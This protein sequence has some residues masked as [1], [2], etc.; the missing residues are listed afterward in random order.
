MPIITLPDGSEAEFPD[1]MPASEIEAVLRRQFPAQQPVA[2]EPGMLSRIG[3]AVKGFVNDAVQQAVNVRRVQEGKGVLTALDKPAPA[4]AQPS[5]IDVRGAPVSADTYGAALQ[6]ARSSAPEQPRGDFVA[7]MLA[8][9]EAQAP[10]WKGSVMA[11]AKTQADAEASGVVGRP[12]ERSNSLA[13]SYDEP[14]ADT[15]ARRAGDMAKS[16]AQIPAT[17]V[18]SSADIVRLFGADKLGVKTS[19]WAESVNRRIEGSKSTGHQVEAV[20]F[21]RL[22]KSE[23]ATPY[24]ALMFLAEHPEFAVEQAIPS[25]GSM[26]IPLGS[27]KTVGALAERF[28]WFSKL[29]EAQRAEKMADLLAGTG[30]ASNAA[31]NGA[32][33]FAETKGD[34]LGRYGSAL[35]AAGGTVAF[36]KLTHG[37]AEGAL[38]RGR[39][40]ASGAA[41][42][43]KEVGKVVGNEFL[44]EDGEGFSQEIGKQVAETGGVNPMLALRHGA[45][46]GALGTITGGGVGAL[47]VQSADSLIGRAIDDAG[48]RIDG[49]GAT[50]AFQADA[51]AQARNAFNPNPDAIDPVAQQ[52]LARQRLAEATKVESQPTTPLTAEEIV[53]QRDAVLRDPSSIPN[54]RAAEQQQAEVAKQSAKTPQAV[55][56]NP[57][58]GSE[59]VQ[60]GSLAERAR[61]AVAPARQ[62]SPQAD[63]EWQAFPP[64]MG[65]LGVPRAEMP[66]IKAEHRGPL[67]NFLAARGI[68][69]EQ[70]E[71]P[72]RDLKP[73]QAEF[74]VSKVDKAREFQGGDRSILVSADG[75]ILDGHHQW[76][77]KTPENQPVKVI[78]LSAPMSELLPAAREFPSSTLDTVS[79]QATYRSKDEAIVA[80]AE[81]RMGAV[82]PVKLDSGRWALQPA[83]GKAQPTASLKDMSAAIPVSPQED[84]AAVDDLNR[85]LGVSTESMSRS[86]KAS[87]G[88]GMVT[89]TKAVSPVW[90]ATRQAM[91]A[92]GVHGVAV[93]GLTGGDGVAWRNRNGRTVAYVSQ[94]KGFE[95]LVGIAGHEG[96]HAIADENPELYGRYA[97]QLQALLQPKA[98]QK[99]LTYERQWDP[100]STKERARE[101]VLAD[102]SGASWLRE[103]FWR[104]VAELDDNLFRQLRYRFMANMVKMLDA[105]RLSKA[106][107]KGDRFAM[108]KLVT[109]VGRAVDLTA[110]LWAS[111]AKAGRSTKTSSR[112]AA[113]DKAMEQAMASWGVKHSRGVLAEVAP[114]PDKPEAK[115]WRQL[116]APARQQVTDRV[117]KRLMAG[118]E[119]LTKL[120]LTLEPAKGAYE[121]EKNP[122]M[123]IRAEGASD[124]D[125][126]Q[127]ARVVGYVLDQK[128]MVVFDESDAG[129]GDQATFV[130]VVLPTGM[131]TYQVESL[132]DHI[133]QVA[134]AL[135]GDHTV[136]DGAIAYGNFTGFGDNPMSDDA[137]HDAIDQAVA[138]FDWSGA[139]IE[140]FRQRFRSELIQPESRD[141][142]LEGTIYGDG[143]QKAAQAGRD[144][145]WRGQWG[146]DVGVLRSVADDIIRTRDGW[147]DAQLRAAGVSRVAAG[148]AQ[149]VGE[150]HSAG[151]AVRGVES[152]FGKP[153]DGAVSVIGYHYSK[154]RQSTLIGAMYGSGLKG[155]E[156]ARLDGADSRLKQ[157]IYFYVANSKGVQ[158]ESGVGSHLHGVRLDNLYD[159]RADELG[160]VKLGGGPNAWEA[161][162]I[163]AGF[164]GYLSP[165]TMPT[166]TA[167][168]LGPHSVKV[169]YLGQHGALKYS[170]D[171]DSN[172]PGKPDDFEY[173][174]FEYE[175]AEKV[176]V[177]DHLPRD[178]QP[179]KQDVQAELDAELGQ[180]AAP[181]VDAQSFIGAPNRVRS[182]GLF[183]EDAFPEPTWEERTPE[184]FVAK[185]EGPGQPVVATVAKNKDGSWNASAYREN[186]RSPIGK[187]PGEGMSLMSVSEGLAKGY[188][189]R[190]AAAFWID[191]EGYDLVRQVDRKAAARVTKTWKELAK[192]PGAFE[193]EPEVADPLSG[194]G[195]SFASGGNVQRAQEIADS[196]L[197]GSRF[198]FD[199]EPG[200]GGIVF[201]PRFEDGTSGRPAWMTP[202]SGNQVVF[203]AQELEKG[204]GWG[205]AFYQAAVLVARDLGRTVRAD[206]SLTSI[207][208]YRRTEQSLSA[209][210]RSGGASTVLPGIAQRVYGFE[211]G[212]GKAV[213]DANLLRLLLASA[214]NAKEIAP[215]ADALRYDIPTQTFTID[216]ENA[217]ERVS[218]FLSTPDARATGMSKATLARAAITFE[219]MQGQVEIPASMP[220]PLLYSRAER[221]TPMDD[222]RADGYK[223]MS[224]REVHV[225]DSTTD[226]GS[227]LARLA[228]T[229]DEMRLASQCF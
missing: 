227:R 174:P 92:M 34:L 29:P 115:G 148:A 24:T 64:D 44:Q 81:G 154:G 192:L 122:A 133:M 15:V 111:K 54:R 158:P 134:P 31:M 1:D 216:G 153:R 179:N 83:Q 27:A 160:L 218:E 19:D 74:S 136:R 189:K 184:R 147:A 38:I 21:D 130:K 204:S 228:E 211:D 126:A 106:F 188:A 190:L 72:A 65:S 89:V 167:V 200:H 63:P 17:I 161:R 73:T 98:I 116:D 8:P 12:R 42:R 183:M 80:A 226:A 156:R 137:F 68:T 95:F 215:W 100:G 46:E 41:Q 139:P 205:K 175:D 36:G 185:L 169:D 125:L 43:A 166:P 182:A 37:G 70:T 195:R 203:H 155:A 178:D 77:A 209:A 112:E 163:D 124:Q 25:L 186:D 162:I 170:R 2:E 47:H 13:P 132:R 210:L 213:S 7:R 168:L 202:E 105:L 180:K 152:R 62:A 4:G 99:R 150:L 131:S 194:K 193:F 135:G 159:V 71:M 117:S 113:I 91:A 82:A 201:R 206:D 18:K 50:P 176:V 57:V 23:N 207:N 217:D 76:L 59:A 85:A 88:P 6:L 16:V 75:Y 220:R 107:T 67:V 66:Q 93:D 173:N 157:R 144:S 52:R 191:D 3:G 199:V 151:G 121:G 212:K 22:M 197:A 90:E 69:H 171:A 58:V 79:E 187:K 109:D 172:L 138:S 208:T 222:F 20:Q 198:Q 223:A 143:N 120:Q 164:D 86:S 33:N 9:E 55:D 10:G 165:G 35:V 14:L 51:D 48:R 32:D 40:L 87:G 225:G 140:T 146:G 123:V 26:A 60:Q 53:A 102:I 229:I 56:P 101:E 28:K 103:D 78:R 84:Q 142:Y 219:A 181:T 45:V 5:L 118:L 30:I 97:D 214:R 149:G 128:A 96:L 114:N 127:L 119:R 177:D 49:L 221:S 94:R 145:F 141:G 224:G 104:K 110:E 61:G 39:T 108:E 129:A 11:K 196:L